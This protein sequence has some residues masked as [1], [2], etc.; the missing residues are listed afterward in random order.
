MHQQTVTSLQLAKR[1]FCKMLKRRRNTG[2]IAVIGT[3]KSL[4]NRQPVILVSP[5]PAKSSL[6]A[7]EKQQANFA[8]LVT[9]TPVTTAAAET[10][11]T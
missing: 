6:I 4:A 5:R 3:L 1:V 10:T 8:V 2:E 11:T 7:K 9:F